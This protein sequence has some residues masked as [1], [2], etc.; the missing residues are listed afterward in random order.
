MFLVSGRVKVKAFLFCVNWSLPVKCNM[1]RVSSSSLRVF[2]RHPQLWKNIFS[3]RSEACFGKGLSL[4]FYS[5]AMLHSRAGQWWQQ[6]ICHVEGIVCKAV[7]NYEP[8]RNPGEKSYP[9]GCI[10]A[11][12]QSRVTYI[13]VTLDNWVGCISILKNNYRNRGHERAWGRENASQI[14]KEKLS[15]FLTLGI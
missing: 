11:S 12:G 9:I 10:I 8:P 7:D 4:A 1:R 6:C 13:K 2:P 15:P 3:G 5:L 14:S